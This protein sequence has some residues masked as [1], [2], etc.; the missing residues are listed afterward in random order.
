[1]KAWHSAYVGSS[2]NVAQFGQVQF[3]SAPNQAPQIFSFID[4]HNMSAQFPYQQ[5]PSMFF[6]NLFIFDSILAFRLNFFN[7]LKIQNNFNILNFKKII[8]NF[9]IIYNK[10]SV[11]F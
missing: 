11:I 9:L 5:V 8:F 4:H 10:S 7:L 6:L 3:Q 2:S 1:V